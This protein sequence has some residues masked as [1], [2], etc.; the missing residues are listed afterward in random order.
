ML[1]TLNV[2]LIV[3]DHGAVRT[4]LLY[5]GPWLWDLLQKLPRAALLGLRQGGAF[6]TAAL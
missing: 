5:G 6:C 3:K 4:L 1:V 2:P